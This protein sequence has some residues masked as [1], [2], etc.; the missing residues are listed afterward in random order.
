MNAFLSPLCI[1]FEALKYF[2]I[3][4]SD[5]WMIATQSYDPEGNRYIHCQ[6]TL[7][8]MTPHPLLSE[9]AIVWRPASQT[10]KGEAVSMQSDRNNS[11]IT[12]NDEQR[13]FLKLPTLSGSPLQEVNHL[14]SQ[15][16]T[17]DNNI[18][19]QFAPILSECK[20]KKMSLGP[21]TKPLELPQYV[22]NTKL[23]EEQM[24]RNRKANET[25]QMKRIRREEQRKRIIQSA[26]ASS[27]EE[28]INSVTDESEWGMDKAIFSSEEDE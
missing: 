8:T 27:D 24:G 1:N 12:N 11:F 21:R 25:K 19:E 13:A 26:F 7:D 4:Y 20:R 6:K 14:T 28:D 22:N 3:R 23:I 10:T 5:F 9:A 18:A 2:S 15:E 17:K 16:E